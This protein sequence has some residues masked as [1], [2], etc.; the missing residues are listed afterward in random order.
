MSVILSTTVQ[1]ARRSA[2]AGTIV[3]G[4]VMGT[5]SDRREAFVEAYR[6]AEI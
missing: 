5:A 4:A 2:R 3:Q 1:Y 6:R